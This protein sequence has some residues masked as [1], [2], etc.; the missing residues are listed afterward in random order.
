MQSNAGL[1][2]SRIFRDTLYVLLQLNYYKINSVT[3]TITTMFVQDLATCF[4]VGGRHQAKMVQ[5]V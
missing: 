2:H 4:D 1:L 5:H 3:Y